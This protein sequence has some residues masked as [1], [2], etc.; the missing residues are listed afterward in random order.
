MLE[1]SASNWGVEHAANIGIK[2][3]PKMD[4]PSE[5]PAKYFGKMH[6]IERIHIF[7]TFDAV[8]LL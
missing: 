6:S 1:Q 3:L 8:L 2:W 4:F 7:F 5:H